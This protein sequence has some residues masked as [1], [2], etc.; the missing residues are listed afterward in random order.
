MIQ[1]SFFF[2][3]DLLESENELPINL[4]DELKLIKASSEQQLIIKNFIE[5]YTKI[6]SLQINRYE[7]IFNKIDEGSIKIIP[8]E[9]P[10]DW[11][12][13]VVE[14]TPQIT[15]REIQIILALSHLDL[16]ILFEA[17]YLGV[18]TTSGEAVPAIQH[19]Q[20]ERR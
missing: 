19:S 13:F 9:N 8:I 2:V 3:G 14:Y 1:Q 16:T 6:V 5:G 12:Y 11:N 4:F 15:F 17:M 7:N 18:N 20:L 10:K